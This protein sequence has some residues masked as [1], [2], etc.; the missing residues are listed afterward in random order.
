MSADM[1]RPLRWISPTEHLL[2]W[3]W[4]KLQTYDWSEIEFGFSFCSWKNFNWNFIV[5][6][7]CHCKDR[8]RLQQS[9]PP[10]RLHQP[11][12]AESSQY[13]T[14][15]KEGSSL[16]TDNVSIFVA[17]GW[18]LFLWQVWSVSCRG[19]RRWDGH[20]HHPQSGFGPKWSRVRIGQRLFLLPLVI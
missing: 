16:L 17:T 8:L 19:T 20:W 5:W 2:G 4:N 10:P 9:T 6:T 14:M 1:K 18:L 12:R 11:P 7:W 13:N 3:I 15:P